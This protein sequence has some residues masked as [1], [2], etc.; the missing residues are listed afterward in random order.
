MIADT[1]GLDRA[2][3]RVD[4][5]MERAELLDPTARKVAR[6]LKG[7]V[8]EFHREGLT[9]IVRHLR[10]DPRGTELLHQ[11]ADDPVVYALLL[12]HQIVRADP[13]TLAAGALAEVSPYL[14]SH[15]G[16]VE[17]VDVAPPV[18]RVRLAGACTGCSA[19]ATTLRDVVE[20]AL[21]SA[22]PGIDRVEVVPSAPEPALIP[23][24]GVRLRPGAMPRSAPRPA[25][26]DVPVES[27]AA[28]VSEGAAGLPADGP[29]P[30][31]RRPVP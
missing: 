16:A 20:R 3:R 21:V 1:G 26:G 23:L 6:D 19:A 18:V 17:L 11:L 2:A 22:V 5:A 13:A 28:E 9:R 30:M 14:H 12:M 25:P 24:D 27:Y 10:T 29:G 8:E 4:I 7:A 15:G 31:T